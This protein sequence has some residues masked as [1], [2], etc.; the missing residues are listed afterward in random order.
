M[1]KSE[2]LTALAS[3]GVTAPNG[4][5]NAQLEVLLA[6]VGVQAGE[7]S[8]DQGTAAAPAATEQPNSLVQPP[9]E[10]PQMVHARVIGQPICE[11]GVHYTKGVLFATT[12]E[13]AAALGDLVEIVSAAETN[14]D[15]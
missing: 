14:T 13:R 2:L 9:P 4:A 8:G 5:T 11:A 3:F 6:E 15:G 7:F 12:A 1:N 10:Q